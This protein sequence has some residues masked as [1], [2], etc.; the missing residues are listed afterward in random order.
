MARESGVF[1]FPANFEVEKAGPLDA[2]QV[3]E[4]LTDMYGLRYTF[5]GMIAVVTGESNAADNGIYVM[6]NQIDPDV[7]GTSTDWA[8]ASGGPGNPVTDF[9]YD[10][11]T[12]ELKITLDD[13]TEHTVTIISSG[14]DYDP[15][16]DDTTTMTEAVGGIDNGT[17]AGEL[18]GK[19]YNEMWDLL[20]FPTAYPTLTAPSISLSNT[21]G[22]QEVG[23]EIDTTVNP[24]V[25]LGAITNGW[26]GT[27]QGTRSDEMTS[28]ELAW[29]ASDATG[30]LDIFDAGSFSQDPYPVTSYVVQL[31]SSANTWTLN[32][33]VSTGPQPVDSKGNSFDSPY[34]GGTFQK[35]TNFEGVYPIYLGL[36][37]GNGNF[38][39]RSEATENTTDGI[40]LV[41]HS[42]G[43]I[44][45]SQNYG[46]NAAG[47]RHRIAVPSSFGSITI[48]ERNFSTNTWGASSWDSGSSTTFTVNATTGAIAYTVYE[49]TGSSSGGDSMFSGSLK[50]KYRIIF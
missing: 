8:L 12:G 32:V 3:C 46:D 35:T 36:S 6:Q 20:L 33:S 1:Q 5:P 26:N 22:L 2:R 19:S 27:S 11:A 21:I 24:G 34:G 38:E 7:D 31:G 49:K 9:V 50:S 23:A 42:G 45:I 48:Q 37:T 16:V 14:G 4:L 15:I 39:K 25:S 43:T 40:G 41:S 28:A 10:D 18:A 29:P 17:T 44:S 47:T 13:G 30:T